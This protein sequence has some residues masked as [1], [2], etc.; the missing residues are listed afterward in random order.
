MMTNRRLSI[1]RRHSDG[2]LPA[3]DTARRSDVTVRLTGADLQRLQ[4]ACFEAGDIRVPVL[5]ARA[6]HL[7]EEGPAGTVHVLAWQHVLWDES[8]PEVRVLAGLIR[9]LK[10]ACRFEVKKAEPYQG[11]TRRIPT[12]RVRFSSARF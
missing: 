10:G 2:A 9:V 8:R 7:L 1:N 6:K 5:L 12:P 3:G 4:D 11:I